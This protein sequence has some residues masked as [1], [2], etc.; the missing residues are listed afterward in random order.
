ME[1]YAALKKY[2]EDIYSKMLKK[3]QGDF[4]YPCFM[5][6]DNY[7]CQLWD[8]GSWMSNV[9]IRQIATNCGKQDDLFE[10][11][12]GCVLQFLSF[13]KEDGSIPICVASKESASLVKVFPNAL[14]VHKPCLAQHAAFICKY[15]KDITWLEDS[16]EGIKK[17]VLY[18]INNAKHK[19]SKLYY[20]FDDFAIG[21]DN[22][23][24]TF[25]RPNNSTASIFL[26]S[27]M[28]KELES[29]VFLAG[30]LDKKEDVLY[31]QNQLNELK[32]AIQV[33]CYDEKDGMFYSCDIN[34]RPIKEDE[35]LHINAP[36][37]Y[38]NL[39]MRIGTWSSFL[40][41]WAGIATKEQSER[42]IK[43]NLLDKKAFWSKYGIRTLSKYEKMY[44]PNYKSSNPSNWHGGIW[45][46]SNYFI[47]SGLK[48]YGYLEEATELAKNTIE[49][50]DDDLC[51]NGCFHEYYNPDNGEGNWDPG[52]LS[53]NLLVMNMINYIE[54][55][56]VVSEF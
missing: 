49:L 18:Y 9:A 34:L 29:I 25:Y 42:M 8:W 44:R 26:N 19:E 10:Y 22:D 52:F 20:F 43:E 37:H 17:F 2:C 13:Q 47:F 23:P 15:N 21:V 55:K 24:T 1:K 39:I 40:P 53:W 32:N 4:L 3:P 54:G 33:N 50:L 30:L 7:A 48:K 14:N 6:I 51:K 28:Y 16:Y 27:L 56:E 41:L 35:L 46:L 38:S 5:P 31:F 45:I 11:E 12:I 36:R